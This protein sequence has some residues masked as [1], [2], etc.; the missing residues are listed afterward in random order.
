MVKI[1]K[2]LPQAKK[3]NSLNQLKKIM[4]TFSVI[5]CLAM[6]RPQL[7]AENTHPFSVHDML[8]MDRI[9]DPQVSPDGKWIVFNLRTTDLEA[10]RGRSD[11]WLVGTDG[12]DLTRLTTHPASDY[13]ARWSPCGKYIWFLST[14]SGSSQV[15]KIRVSGGEAVQ[16][17]DLPLDAGNLIVS[18][19]AI[20]IAFTLEVFP[21]H[22]TPKATKTKLDEIASRKSTGRIYDRIFIRHWDTWKDGR[23]SNLFIM[24]AEGG[25][26][27]NLM[28]G[29]DADTPSK[30]FGGPEEIS[31]T[32]DGSAV[33]FTARNVGREQPWS[34]DFD[35]Y[36][37]PVDGSS[38]PKCLTEENEA[39]DTGPLFSP[40][41]K[42]MA[43]L[44]MQR[45]RFESDRF[46]IVLRS[47]PSGET[48]ILPENWDRSP[49]SLCWSP[50]SKTVYAT[51]ANLGQVSLFAID[52]ATGKTATIIEKGHVRS[53]SFAGKRII[54]G[55]DTLKSPVELYSIDPDGSDAKAITQINAKK[56]VAA[57]MGDYEQFTFKGWNDETVYCY[58]V[59]PV[60]FDSAKKYPVAF[61][62]HGGPQGSFGNDFHYRWNPQAYAGADYAAVMVD[63]HGSVGYGQDFTDSISGDWGG[64]PLVDLQKGLAAA[65]DRCPWM[66]GERVGA[67]G[68]SFGGYMINWIAGNWPDR[69]R[70]LA[71]HDGNLDER[72]AYFDTEELWFPEWDHRG[73]PWTNPEGYEKHNPVNFVQNWKTPMLVIHGAFD[74]RVVETQGMGTFNAL[75]RLG[76]PSKLLYFPDENHWVLKPHNSIQWHETVIGWMD[77]WC[78]K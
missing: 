45:A 72:M 60:D 33:V 74:F 58:I 59:K 70:C 64:K 52:I 42:W 16:S 18:P 20:H 34:T 40:D 3:A 26:C 25:E 47:W 35:L 66:D 21:E 31:F 1:K 19:D 39:W 53:P 78:K 49:S 76:I 13:N 56:V 62:I 32:P 12:N 51:A 5:L 9:S 50:D 11:L 27:R 44:A 8:A 63:F 73:T 65:L 77:Q 6:F 2:D 67:L 41:G 29:M 17:T 69:F 38:P 24:A 54:F 7:A 71:N 68:A 37:V 75:Q 4:L 46:R 30:P 22:P 28:P 15:W 36:S 57:R 23:R 61:L 48:R 14:R 10:N 43:Y 55:M